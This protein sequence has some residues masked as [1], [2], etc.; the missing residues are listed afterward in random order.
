MTRQST[1]YGPTH[2][3]V[4]A[5]VPELLLDLLPVLLGHLLFP[6]AALCLLLYAGDHA[7]RTPPGSDDVLRK[8]T[9]SGEIPNKRSISLMFGMHE[10]F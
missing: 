1:T 5:N 6:L 9:R 7:P 8:K 10:T 4:V 2:Q 3:H